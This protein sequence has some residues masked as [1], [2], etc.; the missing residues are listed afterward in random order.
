MKAEKLRV[1][2][3]KSLYYMYNTMYNLN[4][5]LGDECISLY[6]IFVRFEQ[7]IFHAFESEN[8]LRRYAS[9]LHALLGEYESEQKQK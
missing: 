5:T 2:E 9:S 4:Y 3:W 6:Y 7:K 8:Y 1:N